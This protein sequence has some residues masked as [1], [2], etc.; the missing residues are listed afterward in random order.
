L[1]VS[2]SGENFVRVKYVTDRPPFPE[3][4]SLVEQFRNGNAAFTLGLLSR[5]SEAWKYE[6][7]WR[8]LLLL[9]DGIWNQCAGRDL[10]FADFGSELTLREVI[11]GAENK[12]AA[13][14][15]YDAI[16]DY[17]GPVRVA[18]MRPSCSTL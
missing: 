17:P 5:K 3:T 8:V 12:D 11:F 9:R 14:K 18:R 1:D 6:K 7:E 10:Y 13:C 2:G 16:Q 15:V 4:A